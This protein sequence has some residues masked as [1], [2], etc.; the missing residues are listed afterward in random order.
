M[1]AVDGTTF[2]RETSQWVQPRTTKYRDSL[3]GSRHSSTLTWSASQVWVDEAER[4]IKHLLLL[5]EGWDGDFALPVSDAA[6]ETSRQLVTALWEALPDLE[7]PFVSAS[8]Y[9]SVVLEWSRRGGSHIQFSTEPDGHIG[10]LAV[11]GD[12][13]FEGALKDLGPDLS[14]VLIALQDHFTAR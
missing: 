4:S 5:E 8:I 7:A 6:V 13:E 12:S 10:V 14:Q 1:T 11:V 2:S 3:S 9:G